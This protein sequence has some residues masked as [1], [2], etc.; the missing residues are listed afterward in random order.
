MSVYQ[1]APTLEQAAITAKDFNF[2]YGDFHALTGLDLNIAKNAITSFIGPSG[3]GKSTF[4]RC[5]NR[6]IEPTEGSV[7]FNGRDITHL[8]RNKLRGVR[9]QIAMIFQNYNLVYRLTAIQNVLHGRLGYKGAVAG[10]LGLYSEAE[11]LRAFELLDEVGLGEFAY[12][13]ADQLSG[14]Q[15]QRVGIARALIQD[16]RIILCDEPIAS[17]DPKSSRA[18][19][20]HLR[21]VTRQHGITCIV[22]LHQVDMALEF[23]DR[24]V[25]LRAG[26]KVFEGAPAELT[27]Q[28][29]AVIYG[30]GEE[31]FISVPVSGP[32][33]DATPASVGMA[34]AVP[35]GALQ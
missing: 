12:R 5:I 26:A 22:N 14:G 33:A 6:L 18:V 24:I 7:V 20:E 16:P 23:S 8:R 13:R 10:S 35:S 17:L 11:K 28:M 21:R 29:I 19:M 34:S 27:P 31:G 32:Q 4:L 3:C 15:K 1:S 2:W 30:D 9:A 25:G